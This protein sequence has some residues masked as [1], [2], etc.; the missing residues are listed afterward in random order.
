MD[1]Y[2][3]DVQN[4]SNPRRKKKSK[5]QVFKETYLPFVIV[6]LAIVL[7]IT[8]IIGGIVRG[9][10]RNRAETQAAQDAALALQ[11]EKEA[12]ALEEQERLA[13]AE[14]FAAGYDYDSAIEVL[15]DFSGD[16]EEYPTIAERIEEYEL[17]RLQL[18]AWG[19]PSQIPNLSFQM[20][21]ADLNMALNHQTHASSINRN[22]ITTGEF[23]QILQQL[24]NNGYILVSPKDFL[25]TETTADGQTKYVANPIYLPEGKK[26]LMLTQTN[27][28]Y[29]L[30]L[31][32]SDGDKLA[33][34]NGGGFASKLIL[35]NRGDIT[36]EMVNSSGQIVTGAF[37]LVPILDEFVRMHPDFSYRG[38]KAVLA[39]TGYNGLFGHRTNSEAIEQFGQAAYDEAVDNARAIAARL[40]ETGYVLACYTYENIGYG[41][42][43][44]GAMQS[45]LDRWNDE[46]VPILGQVDMLVYAQ[47]SDIADGWTYSGDKYE[48]LKSKGFSY[49]IGFCEGG[50]GWFYSDVGYVRQGRMLVSG[51]TLAH[52]SDW[53][54]DL[55]YASNILDSGRG[56]VPE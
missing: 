37:D 16:I 42:V 55:F 49:F 20:L 40:E 48:L 36:C 14:A 12:L 18:V 41:D 45:D 2:R 24:Y 35:D 1:E 51:S 33:D 32:D 54:A 44:I 3:N 38:A 56:N 46:V 34:K 43:G 23:T 39:L 31:I 26:P 53:F 4:N 5:F 30:Y 13:D 9:V 6:C 47:G 50:N 15:E 27:V 17:A 7:I 22:F 8:I 19:D 21:I 11:A 10:Q 28:N 25:R 29:N 52:N